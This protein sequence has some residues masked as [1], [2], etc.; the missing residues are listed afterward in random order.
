MPEKIAQFL[1]TPSSHLL[2][3]AYNDTYVDRNF[4]QVLSLWDVLFGTY[5]RLEE[6]PQIGLKEYRVKD[7][8]FLIHM[9]PVHKYIHSLYTRKH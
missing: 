3:H 5:V 8:I 7:N 4:A 9:R 2:H 1:V 6:K